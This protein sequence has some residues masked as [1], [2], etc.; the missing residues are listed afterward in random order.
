V[1]GVRIFNEFNIRAYGPQPLD[2]YFAR[3]NR[4]IVILRT[5]KDADRSIDNV[6]IGQ[7]CCHAIRIEKNVG[8]KLYA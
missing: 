5:V 4:V 1:R 2:V 7:K 3:S 6:G 8:R